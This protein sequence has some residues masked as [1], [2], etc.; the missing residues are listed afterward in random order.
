M[1]VAEPSDIQSFAEAV[2]NGSWLKE[3]FPDK[4]WHQHR[5]TDGRTDWCDGTPSDC[6]SKARV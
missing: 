5:R 6:A 3:K 4:D 1:T 2:N